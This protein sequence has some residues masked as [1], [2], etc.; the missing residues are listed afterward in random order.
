M[1]ARDLDDAPDA[2]RSALDWA[3]AAHLGPE[4]ARAIRA[5][6]R[7]RRRLRLATIG[8]TL[9]LMVALS[10][11]W[12]RWDNP[13][14]AAFVAQDPGSTSVVAPERRTLPDGSVVDLKPGANL[15]VDFTA[16]E[17][18]VVLLAGEAYF[19]VAKNP[20]RPFV[21]S[22][23]GVAVRA[24]GTA[25][26]VGCG[27]RA[28]E[29][30]VTEGIVALE[31]PAAPDN[32]RP[33]PTQMAAGESAVVDVG[34]AAAPTVQSLSAAVLTQRLAWRVPRLQ[35]SGTPLAEV[36][37]LFR[38]HGG[39]EIALAEASLGQVRVSGVLRANNTAALLQLLSADHDIVGET[40]GDKLLLRRR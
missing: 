19:Q 16:A 3:R 34:V 36:V 13:A 8:A 20:H 32:A 23:H 29:V 5:E 37:A 25:F 40:R 38:Q 4:L 17:R 31:S 26:T 9:G 14:G 33:Q 10:L 12:L 35:F 1:N 15:R 2:G 22:T 18:R 21:V 24:V 39:V 6:V 30:V 11:A 7:R 28:V 27:E